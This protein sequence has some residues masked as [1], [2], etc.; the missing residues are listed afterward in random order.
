MALLDQLQAEL[1]QLNS[2]GSASLD[3][4]E[5]ESEDLLA[6]LKAL[7]AALEDEC[8][9]PETDS[10]HEPPTLEIGGLTQKWYKNSMALL[11]TYNSQVGKYTKF[12]GNPAKFSVNL[13]DAYPYP[14]ALSSFPKQEALGME[15]VAMLPTLD[16]GLGSRN[17]SPLPELALQND[18]TARHQLLRSI[19]LHLLKTGYGSLVGDMLGDFD[20]AGEVDGAVLRQFQVLNEIVESIRNKHDLTGALAWL[21]SNEASRDL[22]RILFKLHMLQFVLLLAGDAQP[23]TL[24]ISQALDAY[25]YAKE[26]FPPYVRDYINEISSV[27]TLLLFK[28]TDPDTDRYMEA[29]NSNMCKAFV[30]LCEKNKRHNAETL[31]VEDLLRNFDSVHQQHELFDNLAHEFVANFCT[32]MSLSS[33]LSLFQA[34]LAG[35]VN[36]PNFYKY[37]QLLKKIGRKPDP[38]AA[39]TDLPFQLPD[40]NQFLFKFHPIFIC[41]VTKEQSMPLTAVAELRDDKVDRR[42]RHVHVS[43]TKILVAPP[44]PVVVFE[45]CRHLA[46]SDSV[47]NLTKG[48]AEVFKCHYCYKKHKLLDVSNAYFIDL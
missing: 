27:V 4:L 19:V 33:E 7:E 41:P 31:F 42:K 2:V 46:L 36:L 21:R 30:D 26:H 15:Q 3:A 9:S 13:D 35:F 32:G 45:H 23:A 16:P 6:Q 20:M 8:H 43:P 1:A 39:N 10:H 22:E 11:K 29:L 34:V 25:T 37:S 44:N 48:G 12:L 14:L 17:E 40:K 28:S 18:P 38:A 47:R 5:A 24:N